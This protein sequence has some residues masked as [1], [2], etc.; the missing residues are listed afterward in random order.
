MQACLLS[1]LAFI[2]C[3]GIG[4]KPGWVYGT[5]AIIG[6]LGLVTFVVGRI[7]E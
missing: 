7:F 2:S 4:I 6:F 5:L 1:I 3:A